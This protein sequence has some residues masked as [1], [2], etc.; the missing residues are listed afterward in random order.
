MLLSIR[1]AVI[2]GI[3][4]TESADMI[5]SGD[6]TEE[7]VLIESRS[8]LAL[9]ENLLRSY[10]VVNSLLLLRTSFTSSGS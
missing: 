5:W 10:I 7:S 6:S 2:E 3:F 4:E 9:S 1:E 8:N